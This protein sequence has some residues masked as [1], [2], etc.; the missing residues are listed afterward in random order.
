MLDRSASA[1]AIGRCGA[2]PAQ[3]K[4]E[5]GACAGAAEMLRLPRCCSWN[6]K[7][8]PHP[9]IQHC[10]DICAVL[11]G[12]MGAFFNAPQICSLHTHSADTHCTNALTARTSARRS[13]R[14]AWIHA[15]MHCTGSLCALTHCARA[16]HS[17]HCTYDCTHLHSLT[18]VLTARAQHRWTLGTELSLRFTACALTVDGHCV[19]THCTHAHS[20]RTRS[21]HAHSL[22]THSPHALTLPARMHTDCIA[23]HT[24][25][26]AACCRPG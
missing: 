18:T 3:Q 10:T 23:L 14:T 12:G 19:H 1:A 5:A 7:K 25:L 24:A 2:V 17:L 8:S 9:P 4:S 15:L 21:L 6:Q 26:Q 13:A 11:D 16:L 20:L 22:H